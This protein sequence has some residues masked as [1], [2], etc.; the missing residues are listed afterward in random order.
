MKSVRTSIMVAVVV[1]IACPAGAQQ[2]PTEV[3]PGE[4]TQTQ[5][6]P[7][8]V[9]FPM[10]SDN[11][12]KL[13]DFNIGLIQKNESRLTS[14]DKATLTKWKLE[15]RECVSVVTADNVVTKRE[16]EACFATFPDFNHPRR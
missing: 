5:P 2:R 11:F 16:A 9:H 8:I 13:I 14:E 12:R 3:H 4:T 7:P 1:A 10:T 6:R 15:I